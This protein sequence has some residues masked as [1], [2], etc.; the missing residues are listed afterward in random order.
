M[1]T[2]QIANAAALL[3]KARRGGPLLADLPVDVRPANVTDAHAIQDAVT[4]GLGRPVGAFKAMAPANGEATRGII[5]ADTVHASPARI[6]AADVPQCGVEGEVAFVFRRDLPARAT[7]S[8]RDEVAAAVDACA[9]IEVVTS[10]Y[11]NSDAV[12]NLEKLA[13]SI[14]NGAFVHA[15]S[16][17]DWRGLELG[18]LRVTLTVNGAPVL[19]QV[20]GHPTGDPRRGGAGEHDAREGRRARR[21]VRDL[22]FVHRPAVSA[23]W[24]CLRR[25]LRGAWR[26]GGDFHPLRDRRRVSLSAPWGRRG[27]G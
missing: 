5:Y 12:S 8:S 19:E 27:S 16:P 15:A 2:H 10:R 21:T 26:G 18:R 17:A 25:A 20:G 23:A 24:R 13:D 3:V 7:P 22:R 6:P 1:E 9:A 4:A 14:S 11:Q